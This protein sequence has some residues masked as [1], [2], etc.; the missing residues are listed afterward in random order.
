MKRLVWHFWAVVDLVI[1]ILLAAMIALVFTNVVLRYGFSSGIRQSVELARLWF[2]WVVMLGAAV[3]LRRGEHLA[4]AEF[5]EALFPRAVP[6]LRRLCWLVVIVAVVMLFI[7]A[8]NQTMANWNNISQLTGL[9][10]ALFYLAGV[11]S[12]VM[13]CAI[14]IIRLIDPMQTGIARM[15]HS[16]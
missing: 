14:A 7:G 10:S 16:E 1:A 2:V 3:A 13:M 11:V 8:L 4:V 15:E 9:P 6:Y 12:A 5:S